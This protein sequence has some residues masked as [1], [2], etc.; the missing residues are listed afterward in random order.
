M[1]H[2]RDLPPPL[3]PDIPHGV[4]ALIDATLVKD[5]RSRYGS[6]GEFAKAVAAVRAGLPLPAPSGLP[7]PHVPISAPVMA[8]PPVPVSSLDTAPTPVGSVGPVGPIGSVGA[9]PRQRVGVWVFVIVLLVA[10][11]LLASWVVTRAVTR[12]AP[13]LVGGTDVYFT[14]G[15][16][17]AGTVRARGQG[18]LVTHSDWP[19]LYVPSLTTRSGTTHR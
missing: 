2:I 9:P 15:H 12:A 7:V 1:M 18:T 3:P 4:R 6:G 5:P 10:A 14:A 11:L 16:I 17:A 8:G 13:N 19:H